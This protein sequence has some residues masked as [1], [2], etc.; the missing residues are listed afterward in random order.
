MTHVLPRLGRDLA[1][2]L[3]AE[4]TPLDSASISERMP[5]S[6]SGVT[7]P[8]IGGDRINESD[9]T[10]LRHEVVELA[11]DHGMPLRLDRRSEFDARCARILHDRLSL[12]PHEASTD[13]AW[14]YITCCWLLDVAV[15]RFEGTRATVRYLGDVNR[16]TFRRLWWRAE[17]LGVDIDLRLFGEDELVNI[18]ERPT[19]TSD[20]RLARGIATEFLALVSAD[21]AIDRMF[22]MR[23]A[24]KR[25]VRLTPFVSFSSLDDHEIADV[26]ADVFRTAS[27][28]L[29]GEPLARYDRGPGVAPQ[30]SPHVA[31]I[32]PVLI[33]PVDG[34]GRSSRSRG[35]EELED[36]AQVA[37]GIARRA[38]SVTNRT[39]REAA[40]IEPEEATLVLNALV[41]RGALER[42]GEK[43]GTHYVV[44]TLTRQLSVEGGEPT[45]RRPSRESALRRWMKRTR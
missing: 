1:M 31:S 16:N 19:I 5:I 17:V 7:F 11:R 23:D 27:A 20:S 12:T 8:P 42:R 33:G 25:F 15:W 22:L 21:P 28:A 40:P 37:L 41:A 3:I 38:G 45:A 6:E 44:P 10:G 9:L 24:M 35:F 36:L 32:A 13:D 2:E 34:L 30:P 39:L 43:R 4:L 29:R 14:S 26:V 18:M